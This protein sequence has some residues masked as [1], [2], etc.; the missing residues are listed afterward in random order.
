M[1]EGTVVTWL[2]KPGDTV[3]KDDVVL[4][5]STDKVD[6]DVESPTDGVL[7]EIIVDEGDTVPVG[8][9]LAYID[10]GRDEVDQPVSATDTGS[11]TVPPGKAW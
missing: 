7:R 3:K 4:V 8:T 1:T 10:A 9:P 5:I 6:M 11:M 2:K